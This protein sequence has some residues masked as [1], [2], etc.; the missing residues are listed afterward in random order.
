MT[1]RILR[2]LNIHKINKKTYRKGRSSMFKE[3]R[4]INDSSLDNFHVEILDLEYQ[5]IHYQKEIEIILVMEGSPIITI[6]GQQKTYKP[7]DILVISPF[8]THS[9]YSQKAVSRLLILYLDPNFSK[10]YFP[11]M[12][13]VRFTDNKLETPN[14]H[15]FIYTFMELAKSYINK[16]EYYQLNSAG[17]INIMLF[18]I[19]TECAY[20]EDSEDKPYLIS[21]ENK[22]MSFISEYIQANSFKKIKLEDLANELDL[23]PTY[24]S[25]FIKKHLNRT[26]SD[27]ISYVRY[28]N[29]KSMIHEM[30]YSLNDISAIVGFSDYRYMNKAFKNQLGM[31]PNEYRQ[32]LIYQPLINFNENNNTPKAHKEMIRTMDGFMTKHGLEAHY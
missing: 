20:Y 24:L 16:N 28:V 32:K 10:G 11:K 5:P 7:K 13:N 12:Q 25:H 4:N 23:S 3:N 29:A 18:Y 22:R 8:D 1:D 21:T 30:N 17:F 27:Y 19:L 31:T 9:I 26:F 2:F 15:L 14:N 6:N